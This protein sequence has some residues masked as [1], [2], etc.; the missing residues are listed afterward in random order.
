M[1]EFIDL[2]V[3]YQHAFVSNFSLRNDHC[4][5][6]ALSGNNGCGKSTLLKT[7]AGLIKPLH[8]DILLNANNL[9]NISIKNRAHLLTLNNLQT[10]RNVFLTVFDYLCLGRLPYTGLLGKLSKIDIAKVNEYI[11]LF[12]LDKFKY[13]YL[14]CISEGEFQRIQLAK[15]L[16]QDTALI[17]LDEPTAFMDMENKYSTFRT[18]RKLAHHQGKTIIVA[19]HDLPFIEEEAD[20]F[21]HIQHSI[22]QISEN[23]VNV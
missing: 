15:C 14:N 17:L 13:Q 16:I 3:G 9:N 11:T 20:E 8:G 1:F 22:V 19:T 18:L 12:N 23:R 6:I 5:L 2:S 4:K 10:E 21:W 7:I